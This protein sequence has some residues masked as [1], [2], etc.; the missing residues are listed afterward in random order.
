[1]DELE[2]RTVAKAARR[3]IPFLILAYFACILDRGNVG[4]AA[5]TMNADLG[6][7]AAAFGLGAG[8]FF[9]PYFLCEVPSNLALQRF[10]ARIWIARITITWGIVSAANAFVWNETSFYGARALLGA[11][12]A[13]FFPGILFYLMAW[14]PAAYRGRIVAAFMVAIPVSLVIGTPISGLLLGM[15]GVLGLKGWQWM[16]IID[17]V[18]AIILGVLTPFVLP[19]TPAEARW[20]SSEERTWL[21]RRLAQE[22]ESREAVRHYSVLEA[23]CDPRVLALALAYFGM[24]GLGGALIVYLPQL[25]KGFGLTNAQS[26]FLAAVPYFIACLGMIALGLFADRPGRRKTAAIMSLAIAALG[27]WGSALL[28]DPVPKLVMLSFASV[29]V[30]GCM[31]VFWGLPTTF[32]S[33][34]AA[35]AGLALIN[36]LGSL[37]NFFNTWVFGLIR[38][39]TG[40]YNGGLAELGAMAA[41]AMVVVAFLGYESRPG[42]HTARLTRQPRSTIAS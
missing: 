25:L 42:P 18:P 14:F 13:G 29:G 34:A 21:T 35:A 15:D 40:N 11:A 4:V 22:A 26:G 38:E 6:L 41:M 31:P 5:L 3:L 1:M 19:N 16:F 17:A 27:L 10:G 2:A 8:I 7:N 30:F 23:M 9:I 39:G 12:E 20:L 36:A 28:N 32:L 37:S 33:G 24:N